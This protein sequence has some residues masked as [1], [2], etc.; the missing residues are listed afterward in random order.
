MNGTRQRP[1]QDVP[2]GAALL[3]SYGHM[4]GH[5]PLYGPVGSGDVCT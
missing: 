4:D 5:H 1:V 2:L 3:A